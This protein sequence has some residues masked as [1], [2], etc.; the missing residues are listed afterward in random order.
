MWGMELLDSSCRLISNAIADV[1]LVSGRWAEI[2]VPHQGIVSTDASLWTLGPGV[3]FVRIRRNPFDAFQERLMFRTS[4][5]PHY[6]HDCATAEPL[7]IP[8][9]I[10][11]EMVYAE[12]REVFRV[13]TTQTGRIHAWTTGPQTSRKEPLIKLSLVNCSGKTELCV[14][15]DTTGLVT[16]VL[17][18]GTYY[19]SAEPRRPRYLGKYTL[20]V[21]F[22]EAKSDITRRF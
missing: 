22:E 10:E 8:G 18:P 21:D 9:L 15:N 4:F 14:D 11:G 19:L 7:K 20:H 16:R 17:P 12:D 3:Y 1:S 5:I 13:T 2:T 6:G